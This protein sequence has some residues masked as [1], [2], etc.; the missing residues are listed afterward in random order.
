[1][2]YH[3]KGY[4]QGLQWWPTDLRLSNTSISYLYE[5]PNCGFMH[6]MIDLYG[7]KMPEYISTLKKKKP[8]I[9]VDETALIPLV[10]FQWFHREEMTYFTMRPSR[11]D[12]RYLLCSLLTSFQSVRPPNFLISCHV[13]S[14]MDGCD[15]LR[16]SRLQ[17]FVTLH[18]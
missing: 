8:T 3:S 18:N 11:S 16:P 17:E 15:L 9:F 5:S 14:A 10:I 2:H 12:G 6:I 13:F 7:L 1:M 4:Q